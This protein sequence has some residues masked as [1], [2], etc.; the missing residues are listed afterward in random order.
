MANQEHLEALIQ[1]TDIWNEWRERHPEIQPDLTRAKLSGADFC[2]AD[3]HFANLSFANLSEADLRGADLRGAN[4]SF[5][6]LSEADLRSADLSGA[7][8]SEADFNAADLS[9]ANLIGANLSFANLRYTDLHFANLHDANLHDAD[10]GS[11]NLHDA[12]FS[13]ANLRKSDLIDANLIGANLIRANLIGADLSNADLGGADLSFADLRG[14]DLR[15]ADLSNADL[16]G[17]DLS[18]ADLSGAILR[19]TKLTEAI[20][21]ECRIYGLSA[22]DVES[23]GAAQNSLVIVPEDQPTIA[24]DNLKMAQFIYLFLNNQEIREVIYTIA[25]KAVLILGRFTPE[26]KAVLDA[27]RDELRRH[28]YLPILFDFE[29]PSSRNFTETVRTLAHLSR[30][31]IADL[32]DPSSIPQELYA[33][34]PTLAVPIQ[35]LLETSRSEY[36]MFS[37]LSHTSHW[38]LPIYRYADLDTLLAS[39]QEQILDPAEQK[40]QELIKQKAQELT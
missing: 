22:W 20:L 2:D 6:N 12:D 23:Q 35:P 21:T 10:L 26:R 4:L 14:A 7:D 1:G 19:G 18:N 29:K 37:D 5:A 27:L 11:A 24:V 3:L 30:F 13:N 25:K 39:F 16:R 9:L 40:A 28:G 36:S 33:I 38:I 17:A 31:I 32:T 8:L 34:A 15:G